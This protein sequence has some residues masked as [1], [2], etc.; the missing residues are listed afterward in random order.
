M[1]G[2]SAG[3]GGN[4]QEA[5]RSY[6][7]A[8]RL[9]PNHFNSLYF[10]ALRLATDRIDR[11]PEA[12]Q[13]LTACLALRPTHQSSYVFRQLHHELG[14]LEEAEAD[15]TAAITLAADETER[16][17][18]Y[19]HRSAFHY[20]L[21][22]AE[23][24]RQDRLIQVD[25]IEKWLRKQKDNPDDGA[26]LPMMKTLGVVYFNLGRLQEAIALNEQ[27]LE[28][29]KALPG[30]NRFTTQ[31]YVYNLAEVYHRA[32]RPRDA[33]ALYER[34]LEEDKAKLGPR[35]PQTLNSADLLAQYYLD[36]DLGALA[37]PLREFKL[38]AEKAEKRPDPSQLFVARQQMAEAYVAAGRFEEAIRTLEPYFQDGKALLGLERGNTF[39]GLSRKDFDRV[40]ERLG[41]RGRHRHHKSA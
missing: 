12:I 35:D 21:G 27:T 9:Q 29:A 6:E 25:L 2:H 23:K 8:L 15:F 11:K 36:S 22:R 17:F 39:T 3:W 1:A 5:I 7:A 33:I 40:W 28:K 19:G 4:L 32:G 30:S 24:A 26:V 37:V 10:L 14:H 31:A 16:I 18:G 13:L 20:T 38:Q 34:L 41:F